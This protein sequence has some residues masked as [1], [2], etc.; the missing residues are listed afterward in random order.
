M[1]W[2][3]PGIANQRHEHGHSKEVF[4]I[5]CPCFFRTMW[6]I[7]LLPSIE[8]R[9]LLRGNVPAS[10]WAAWWKGPRDSAPYCSTGPT[11]PRNLKEILSWSCSGLALVIWLSLLLLSLLFLV[12]FVLLVLFV[13]NAVASYCYYFR[14]LYMFVLVHSDSQG[15]PK[16]WFS[17]GILPRCPLIISKKKSFEFEVDYELLW[18]FGALLT[19]KL[20]SILHEK[21]IP[22]H[23]QVPQLYLQQLQLLEL[24]PIQDSNPSEASCRAF[25]QKIVTRIA[26]SIT[27]LM[28]NIPLFGWGIRLFRACF[29][30]SRR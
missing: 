1:L 10:G 6:I 9:L 11:W 24:S 12:L 18:L 28:L 26:T 20:A 8:T 2:Y 29:N 3:W 19:T 15:H 13:V 27:V 25:V 30:C 7:A 21:F 23:L 4:D 14:I 16:R 17:S 5:V 22:F